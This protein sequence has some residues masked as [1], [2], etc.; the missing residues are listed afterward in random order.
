M[1]LKEMTPEQ[2]REYNRVQK[3]QQR[4]RESEEAAAKRIPNANG[5]RCQKPNRSCWT[6]TPAT[7]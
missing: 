1:K 4:D 6:S 7:S 2:R 3:Q 5:S